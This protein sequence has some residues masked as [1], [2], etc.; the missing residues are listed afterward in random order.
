MRNERNERNETCPLCSNHCPADNL[1]CGK[2]HAY[3][4]NDSKT[5]ENRHFHREYFKGFDGRKRGHLTVEPAKDSLLYLLFGCSHYL[6]EM[7]HEKKIEDEKVL[8]A[9]LDE[10]EQNQLKVLLQKLLAR[11]GQSE[12]KP[13]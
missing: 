13:E 9:G 1:K 7:L 2:G 11:W 4:K 10:T 8:F 5:M 12:R 6:H 3:F